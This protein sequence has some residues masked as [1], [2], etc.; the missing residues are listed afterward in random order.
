MFV[1]SQQRKKQPVS[2]NTIKVSLEGPSDGAFNMSEDL[3]LY[4]RAEKGEAALR[5]YGWESGPW[6]SIGRFQP[7]A[8]VLRAFPGYRI[9]RRPTGGAAVR[10]VDEITF[11]IA[12]PLR[13]LPDLPIGE[14]GK[15]SVKNVYRSVASAVVSVLSDT[16]PD[17]TLGTE[18]RRPGASGVNPDCFSMVDGPDV[19]NGTGQKLAGSALKIGREAVLLQVS[20]PVLESSLTALDVFTKLVDFVRQAWRFETRSDILTASDPVRRC[21]ALH[22]DWA[23]FGDRGW[24]EAKRMYDFA[25]DISGGEFRYQELRSALESVSGGEVPHAAPDARA[26]LENHFLPG[27]GASC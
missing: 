13:M 22:T 14:T 12:L 10:H 1:G 20:I 6:I 4:R 23:P 25:L 27:L 2:N 18:R 9:V 17:A 8:D 3:N 26:R 15:P 19:V 11:A 16:Y 21:L 7:E 24:S 5:V